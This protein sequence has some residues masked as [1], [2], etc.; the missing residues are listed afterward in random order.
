VYLSSIDRSIDRSSTKNSDSVAPPGRRKLALVGSNV[1][2]LGAVSL[3]TDVS[4]EMVTVRSCP[5][6]SSSA[7]RFPR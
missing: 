3:I 7:C 4:S 2:V 6:T 5:S 1:F